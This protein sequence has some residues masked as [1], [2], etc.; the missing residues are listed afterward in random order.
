LKVHLLGS[1]VSINASSMGLREGVINW[2]LQQL[3]ESKWMVLRNPGIRL[4]EEKRINQKF[5][6]RC[7][8]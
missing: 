4:D 6:T 8:F 7:G 3:A 1:L 5:L 2:S